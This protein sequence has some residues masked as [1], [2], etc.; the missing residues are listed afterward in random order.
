MILKEHCMSPFFCLIFRFSSALVFAFGKNISRIL[1]YLAW[2]SQFVAKLNIG[3]SGRLEKRERR[4]AK[5]SLPFL[6][7]VCDIFLK[8][9]VFV[10][11]GASATM[12]P[13]LP[14]WS[15]TILERLWRLARSQ[16]PW[17]LGLWVAVSIV[18]SCCCCQSLCC[19]TIS[20]LT[21]QLSCHHCKSRH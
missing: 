10:S 13:P 1:C 19:L 6:L 15:Q 2:H 5:P 12:R 11:S 18:A 9:P 7:S 17:Y 4:E 20:S 8:T 16:P 3:A 21:P 14:S